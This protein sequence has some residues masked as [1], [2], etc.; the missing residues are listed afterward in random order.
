[1]YDHDENYWVVLT[2][3]KRS[4]NNLLAQYASTIFHRWV[5]FLY[6][7]KQKHVFLVL[8]S[9]LIGSQNQIHS[10]QHKIFLS[11]PL[12]YSNLSITF[13]NPDKSDRRMRIVSIQMF[14][15]NLNSV[16]NLQTT[17]YDFQNQ[18]NFNVPSSPTFRVNWFFITWQSV[19][20][21]IHWIC[22]LWEVCIIVRH[23]ILCDFN[24]NQEFCIRTNFS[25]SVLL[26]QLSNSFCV[27]LQNKF[28]MCVIIFIHKHVCFRRTQLI[29]H[30]RFLRMI[31]FTL[32]H[33][34][35]C[36]KNN[37]NRSSTNAKNVLEFFP[38]PL[39]WNVSRDNGLSWNGTLDVGFHWI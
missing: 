5:Q 2:L 9:P 38:P 17:N 3:G 20:T 1:M 8:L 10:F 39:L 18:P 27:T 31:G 15:S 30:N 14:I 13:S 21:R 32:I 11:H 28:F 35:H 34:N 26:W 29:S 19:L 33:R 24:N 22:D 4:V 12:C 6:L 7:N 25:Q 36:A 16:L 37:F 23:D